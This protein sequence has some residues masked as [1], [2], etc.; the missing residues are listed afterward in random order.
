MRVQ[1][2]ENSTPRFIP[3]LLNTLGAHKLLALVLLCCISFPVLTIGVYHAYQVHR[4]INNPSLHALNIKR[5]L[6]EMAPQA[7]LSLFNKSATLIAESLALFVAGPNDALSQ[8]QHVELSYADGTILT[9]A[10]AANTEKQHLPSAIKITQ[11]LFYNAKHIGQL[12]VYYRPVPFF[13]GLWPHLKHLIMLFILQ[14]IVGVGILSVF[15]YFRIVRPMRRIGETAERIAN[16][17]LSAAFPRGAKYELEEI[18][19]H[20]EDTRLK[21]IGA[22]TALEQLDA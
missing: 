9:S 14:L 19:R 5:Y 1:L 7:E 17:D 6:R 12:H 18:S 8:V 10:W 13:S 16:G 22:K 21:A 15:V 11:K 20:L 4:D 3:A 2:M